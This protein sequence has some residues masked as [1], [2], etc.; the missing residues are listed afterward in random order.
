MA[1]LFLLRILG[2]LVF[3]RLRLVVLGYP[4]THVAVASAQL[5]LGVIQQRYR[6]V[7]TAFLEVHDECVALEFARVVIVHLDSRIAVIADEEDTSFGEDGSQELRR[8]I[9]RKV[10]DPNRSLLRS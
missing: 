2:R 1:E 6:K 7:H 5:K 3:G 10:G 8:R 9:R 4:Y